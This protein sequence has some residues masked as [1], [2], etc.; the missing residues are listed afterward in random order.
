MS[1]YVWDIAPM[2]ILA[3]LLVVNIK[4]AGK[5]AFMTEKRFAFSLK[6]DYDGEGK[7][8]EFRI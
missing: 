1:V 2:R 4:Y 3:A 6:R 7:A 5:K 8:V